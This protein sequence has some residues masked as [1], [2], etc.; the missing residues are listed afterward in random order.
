LTNVRSEVFTAVTTKNAVF[1]GVGRMVLVRTK[2]LFSA[3][4]GS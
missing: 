4:F 1:C 3:S 2:Y